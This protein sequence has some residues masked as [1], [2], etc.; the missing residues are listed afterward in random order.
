MALPGHVNKGQLDIGV[1]VT[2][3]RVARSGRT[4]T[5]YLVE[6]HVSVAVKLA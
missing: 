5:D 1:L 6:Q 4:N 2:F 3:M